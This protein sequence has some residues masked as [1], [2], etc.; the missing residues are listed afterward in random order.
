[1][2]TISPSTGD[3]QYIRL[4][5][6]QQAQSTWLWLSG[7]VLCRWLAEHH[8]AAAVTNKQISPA[9]TNQ[10]LI[11]NRRFVQ[12]P[13]LIEA[14]TQHCFAYFV[15]LKQYPSSHKKIISRLYC[16]V[17]CSYGDAKKSAVNLSWSCV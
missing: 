5:T 6:S 8:R 10:R 13:N 17:V 12:S 11:A 1:M 14:V 9:K 3:W 4:F 15:S 7:C 2:V 16:M